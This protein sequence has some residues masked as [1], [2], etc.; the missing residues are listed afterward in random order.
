MG[1]PLLAS[2]IYGSASIRDGSAGAVSDGSFKDKF[3]TATF[4]IID[5]CDSSIIGLNIGPGHP[6]DQGTYRSELVGLFGIILV[7]NALCLWADIS[8]GAIEI[9]CDGFIDEC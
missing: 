9:G 6:S 5:G 3:G 4:T 2:I 7:V 8:E 1:A